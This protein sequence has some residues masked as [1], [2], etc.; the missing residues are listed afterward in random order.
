MCHSQCGLWV[1]WG[2]IRRW[3]APSIAQYEYAHGETLPIASHRRQSATG[4][5]DPNGVGLTR[6]PTRGAMGAAARP[7]GPVAKGP[8]RLPISLP[9]RPGPGGPTGPRAGWPPKHPMPTEGLH[10]SGKHPRCPLGLGR[11]GPRQQP[12]GRPS[13]RL[14]G[15]GGA[16]RLFWPVCGPHTRASWTRRRAHPQA[17]KPTRPPTPPHLAFRRTA[18]S[19][20]PLPSAAPS[21]KNQKTKLCQDPAAS[22][23]HPSQPTVATSFDQN[24]S[25]STVATGFDQNP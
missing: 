20:S 19:S 6:P 22:F 24:P 1:A 2:L 21:P 8:P 7:E 16:C 11:V 18:S 5:L 12:A 13:R 15:L 25:R 14:A 10:C 3:T 9:P 17:S 23:E 4:H